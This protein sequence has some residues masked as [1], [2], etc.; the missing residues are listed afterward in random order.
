M[1]V[2][3]APKKKGPNEARYATL[4]LVDDGHKVLP[5]S[6]PQVRRFGEALTSRGTADSPMHK[7]ILSRITREKRGNALSQKLVK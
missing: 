5:A 3:P 1:I 2:G 6:C 7:S 4:L